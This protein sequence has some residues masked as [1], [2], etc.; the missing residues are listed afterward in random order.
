M[1]TTDQAGGS[2]LQ[3]GDRITTDDQGRLMCIFLRFNPTIGAFSTQQWSTMV[4][5]ILNIH[6]YVQIY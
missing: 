3:T 4:V 6:K 5:P 1:D 2:P